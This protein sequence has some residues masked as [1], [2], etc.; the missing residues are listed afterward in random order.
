M[1]KKTLKII[2]S[3]FVETMPVK[4]KESVRLSWD[5]P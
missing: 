1:K 3:I 5:D 2:W 4:K